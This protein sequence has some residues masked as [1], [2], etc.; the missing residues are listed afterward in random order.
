MPPSSAPIGG[1]RR[2]CARGGSQTSSRFGSLFEIDLPN[3]LPIRPPF[4]IQ[5]S[6]TSLPVGGQAPDWRSSPGRG[7]VALSSGERVEWRCPFG[8]V[9][10]RASSSSDRDQRRD[11][12]RR[13]VPASFD[14]WCSS[15]PR[16]GRSGRALAIAQ[17]VS[18]SE[19][20]SA[21]QVR[22]LAGGARR[23]QRR[24][25][26]APLRCRARR[27]AE[28]RARE[29]RRRARGRSTSASRRCSGSEAADRA[30]S[31]SA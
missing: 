21:S 7:S 31:T 2:K 10:S 27:S 14:S 24:C 13:R 18:S 12:A 28:R 11:G 20:P 3:K 25:S 30:R 1:V 6:R 19:P 4:S 26:R 16:S 15:S 29:R 22:E 17:R 5:S 23:P 8:T 9:R